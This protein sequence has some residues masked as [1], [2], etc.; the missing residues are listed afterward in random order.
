MVLA[1]G[2]CG[3]EFAI[4]VRSDGMASGM[5]NS[6]L[7]ASSL[8]DVGQWLTLSGLLREQAKAE[9]NRIRARQIGIEAGECLDE[10]L[11]FYDDPE[12]DLPP[13][14]AFFCESSKLRFKE[15][16]EQ[17]SRERIVGERVRLPKAGNEAA[18]Q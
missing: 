6:S 2:L 10:A 3:L 14:E 5:I 15:A 4:E 8:I 11:K 9:P 17:F 7:E 16:P 18:R 1:C 13:Q 12:N